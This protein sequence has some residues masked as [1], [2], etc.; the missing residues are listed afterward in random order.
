MNEEAQ[1]C[2]PEGEASPAF[3]CSRSGGLNMCDTNSE[4]IRYQD[5]CKSL[6]SQIESARLALCAVGLHPGYHDTL[7]KA[8]RGAVEIIESLRKTIADPPHNLQE[9]VLMKLALSHDSWS[10]KFP[11]YKDRAL[12]DGVRFPSL[13]KREPRRFRGKK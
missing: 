11:G 13:P 4:M 7:D 5:A 6:N 8:V 10:R 2:Q 9:L 12:E 1:K 3:G